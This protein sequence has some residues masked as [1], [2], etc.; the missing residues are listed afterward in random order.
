MEVEHLAHLTQSAQGVMKKIK[1]P[2][3]ALEQ[4]QH[5]SILSLLECIWTAH[6]LE[7]RLAFVDRMLHRLAPVQKH[8]VAQF[9]HAED[10]RH[11]E[12][13]VV[14]NRRLYAHF[15]AKVDGRRQG[16]RRQQHLGIHLVRLTVNATGLFLW[17]QHAGGLLAFAG[18]P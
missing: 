18:R 6:V 11:R 9:L 4:E 2:N 10:G 15:V 8:D 7:Q 14:R 3:K 16:Y 12:D 5:M 13:K 1:C 17:E